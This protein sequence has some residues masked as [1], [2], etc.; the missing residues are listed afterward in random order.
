MKILIAVRILK[1]TQSGTPRLVLQHTKYLSSKGHKVYVVA[2]RINRKAVRK[3]GGKPIK[4][5]VWPVKGMFHRLFFDK[6]VRFYA[7]L[8]NPKLV[9][10]HGDILKQDILYLH[11]CVHYAHE[12]THGKP[13]PD[14][15]AVGQIHGKLLKE[16]NFRLLVC[17]S[18]LMKND[19][20]ERY[21]IV[22]EKLEVIYPEHDADKF[23]IKDKPAKRANMRSQMGYSDENV[24]IGLIT[25]GDFKKR[26][27]QLL[28]ELMDRLHNAHNLKNVQCFV[29]G[30][31]RDQ[32][33]QDE[34][35]KRGL[36][37]VF[38][39]QPSIKEV[40]NY[41]FATDIF[42]LPAWV[43]EFGRSVVEAMACGLPVVVSKYVGSAELIEG[44][45][46]DYVLEPKL[47][48]FEA[49]ILDLVGNQELRNTL[50]DLNAKTVSAYDS[51]K[52]NEKHNKLFERYS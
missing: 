13:L 19:M 1:S 37:E 28:I 30:K 42:V 4:V 20:R 43:E 16:Q 46:R 5:P 2:Q 36:D 27:V 3:N 6:M 47:T 23:N 18:H 24:V 41:Y 49:K 52:Q 39:F 8:I 50:G 17:N 14:D 26:N 32:Y 35:S 40:E 10:G 21:G 31:N 33:Y 29:A 51:Q 9:L 34:I 25:S 15:M 48:Q 38:T 12:L 7:F 11:N 45:A 44:E 22:D